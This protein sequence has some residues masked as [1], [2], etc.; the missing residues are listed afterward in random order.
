MGLLCCAVNDKIPA[1]AGILLIMLPRADRIPILSKLYGCRELIDRVGTLSTRFTA[2]MRI[3]ILSEKES[4]SPYYMHN[5]TDIRIGAS[6]LSE[7]T[8]RTS[9]NSMLPYSISESQHPSSRNVPYDVN[10]PIYG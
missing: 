5:Y 2:D 7:C 1:Y 4:A 6:D 9:I 3:P 8:M 10:V